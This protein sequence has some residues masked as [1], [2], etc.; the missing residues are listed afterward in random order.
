MYLGIVK[1]VCKIV[2]EIEKKIIGIRHRWDKLLMLAYCRS[3]GINFDP[4]TTRF[5]GYAELRFQKGCSVFIGK[6]FRCVSSRHIG[7]DNTVESKISV[8]GGA[9]LS[10]GHHSGM[11]NS[12]INC[13]ESITIG[14]YVNIGA[15]CLIVDSDFHSLDWSD[16]MDGTDVL[17]KRN[18]PVIIKD[19]V[20]IGAHSIVLKGCTIGEK[21]IIGAGS[22]VTKDI[23]D[24]EIWAGNPAK[25]VKKIP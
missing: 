25:F 12:T 1:L 17:K 3:A 19:L 20:F 24:G 5:D 23:P 9:I 6:H 21:S 14:N 8:M 13:H 22:V 2:V 15:G 16:R 7:M 11:T 18:A 10:I 4:A